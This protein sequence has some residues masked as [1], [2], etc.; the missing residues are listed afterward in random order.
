MLESN[1]NSSL[2]SMQLLKLCIQ[3]KSIIIR[4]VIVT[5]LI[6]SVISIIMPKTFK[7]STVLM[8][9]TSNSDNTIL[10]NLGQITI[11]NIISPN[12]NES[13][14]I[15]AI[16]KSRTMAE[17]VIN[18]MN[19]LEL[20]NSVNMEEGIKSFRNDLIIRES[21]EGTISVGFFAHTHW[22]P[23]KE[24]SDN[25][26]QMSVDIVN[27]IVKELD[28]LNKFHQTDEAHYQRK[29][30]EKRHNETIL[31]LYKAEEQLRQFQLKNNTMDLIE[32]TKAA[33]SIGADIKSQIL[34]EEVKLG[35][36]SKTYKSN[37]PEIQKLK[38]QIKELSLQLAELDSNNEIDSNNNILP[39]YSQVPNI[40]TELIRL[41]REVE[42][43]SNLYL[44][45]SE[46]YEASKIQE[47]RDTP[48]IH[49]LDE[50]N[51]PFKR[52][53]PKRKLLVIGYSLIILIGT[54]FYIILFSYYKKN[55]EN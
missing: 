29:F 2:I 30:L 55:I 41:Q 31:N 10:P 11:G 19:L 5:V 3:Y 48:T 52:F 4:N 32:Q 17:S 21:E 1:N 15:F 23:N 8:L 34:V 44:F 37:H 45:L 36:L 26:R 47:A 39:Q 14:S 27:Y 13:K 46:K 25:A 33:I 54:I 38:L 50:A 28:R 49:I 24:T 22:F 12:N 6:V 42:I 35:V 40:S 18:K 51:Y 16:L 20:Y 43:Q 7:S 53:A 9:P